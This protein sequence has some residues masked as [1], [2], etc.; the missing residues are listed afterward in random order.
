MTNLTSVVFAAILAAPAP[1]S[2]HGQLREFGDTFVG[3]WVSENTADFE[4][5]DIVKKGDKIKVR[6]TNE[7]ILNKAAISTKWTAAVNDVHVASGQEMTGWDN[8]TKQ[9]VSFGFG[10]LG[11]SSRGV[12]QKQGDKWFDSGIGCDP[13]GKIGAGTSIRTVVSRD[14]YKVLA[15][16]RLSEAGEP[17][18]NKTTT[19]RR[20]EE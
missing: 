15:L 3:A 4:F 2:D 1:V 17:L 8:S 12:I 9:I 14:S 19:W 5:K 11:G 7:W 6:V 10:S 20:V 16:G 13:T 18:P